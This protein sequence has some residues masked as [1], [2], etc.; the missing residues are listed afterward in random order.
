ME[1][2]IASKDALISQMRDTIDTQALIIEEERRKTANYRSEMMKI[3]EVQMEV[4]ALRLEHGKNNQKNLELV[5]LVE[6]L[7]DEKYSL[8]D[9]ET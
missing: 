4:R 9:T 5:D 7:R 1:E 2:I 6:R 8:I 3:E